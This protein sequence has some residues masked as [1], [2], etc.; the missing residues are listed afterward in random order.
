M[1]GRRALATVRDSLADSV[2]FWGWYSFAYWSSN[3]IYPVTEA[4]W[5]LDQFLFSCIGCVVLS[6]SLVANRGRFPRVDIVE[7]VALIVSIASL[8]ILGSNDVL[9]IWLPLTIVAIVSVGLWTSWNMVCWGAFYSQSTAQV[10]LRRVLVSL[11]VIA[12]IKLLTFLLPGPLDM[13][14]ILIILVYMHVIARG[15]ADGTFVVTDDEER[16]VA[17]GARLIASVWQILLAVVIFVAMWSFLNMLLVTNIG[18]ITQGASESQWAVPMAQVIDMGF[19]LFMLWWTRRGWHAV[20]WSLF[21]QVAFFLLAL[22]LLTVSIAGSMRIAQVFVSASSVLV[23]V[24]SGYFFIQLGRRGSFSPGVVVG[25]GYAV[26]SGI[27][28]LVR[29]IVVLGDVTTSNESF[30]PIFLFAILVT[31]VFFLPARSPGMQMLTTELADKNRDSDSGRIARCKQLAA[32]YGLT[33]RETDVLVLLGRGRSTPY[34]A[35]TLFL[36][37]NTAKTYKRRIYKKLDIHDKQ[38]LLDLME[39]D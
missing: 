6:I 31:I 25:A 7:K 34:I 15:R 33:P 39:N 3:Q 35:E 22:G 23:F 2:G 1:W 18:H 24:F 12:L 29:G 21:W 8:G 11:V 32:S 19:G 14:P 5:W 9:G 17:S 26:I 20:D 13:L 27:D 10:N 28:W 30:V 4:T 38:D 16:H 36:S 37:E